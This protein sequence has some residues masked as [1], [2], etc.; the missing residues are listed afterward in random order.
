MSEDVNDK[1]G[2]K[3]AET[4]SGSSSSSSASKTSSTKSAAAKSS[5]ES[6]STGSRSAAASSKSSNSS[7]ASA[8]PTAQSSTTATSGSKSGG[9]GTESK[10]SGGAAGQSQGQGAGGSGQP[11]H[12][13]S[14]LSYILGPIT[15]AIFLFVD[16]NDSVVRYHA[17]QSLL[18][19]AVI[20]VA[21]L[22][23]KI[24]SVNFI[25]IPL[26]FWAGFAFLLYMA[27]LAHQ[28]KSFEIPVLNDYAQQL[29]DK[30]S[31]SES[32]GK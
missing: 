17:C 22:A 14:G 2:K 28:Q 12:V 29:A 6:K 11:Q 3:A 23:V 1:S 25:G 4:G 7:T 27:Y 15:G 9:G 30:V 31:P 18:I 20:A 16:R 24:L 13:A 32:Q 19:S 10:A 21:W 8:G 26:V 5:S